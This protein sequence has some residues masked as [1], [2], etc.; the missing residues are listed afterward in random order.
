MSVVLI[1]GCSSGL[2]EAAALAFARAGDTVYASMR[3]AAKGVALRK[4]AADARLDVRTVTLDVTRPATFASLVESIV[5]ETGRLD[6]LVNNAGVLKAGAFEDLGET[7]LR[8]VAAA[9]RDGRIESD[10]MPLDETLSIMRT[11]DQVRAQMGLR[12]PDEGP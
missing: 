10:V 4:A 3:D 5:A 8:E 7:G 1:S 11:M 2:G 9:L 12:F 6:V